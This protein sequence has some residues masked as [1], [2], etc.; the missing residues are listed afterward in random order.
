LIHN[1]FLP[2]PASTEFDIIAS[3]LRLSHK[4]GVDYL[5]RRAL[6]HLSSAYQTTLSDCD[7]ASYYGNKSDARCPP[8]EIRSWEWPD[9]WSYYIFSI[10]L[11]RE[12][13]APWILPYAFYCL[14][15][16]YPRILSEAPSIFHGVVHNGVSVGLSVQDQ[17]SFALGHCNQ[18]ASSAVDI[19]RFLSYP[20]EIQGCTSPQRCLS[21]RLEAIEL[22]RENLRLNGSHPLDLWGSEEWEWLEDLCPACLAVLKK[23][24]QDAR[25]AFWD[26]LP[27]LYGLPPWEELEKLK[28]AAIGTNLFC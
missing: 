10:Q 20:P 13:D 1:F 12:V 7:A 16:T 2:F 4:Y 8:A 28:A 25:Q 22:N 24:H 27:E 5:H 15:T 26:K 11:A 19:L 17:Q 3:C 9:T 21:E 23:T 14:A 6:I 18:N